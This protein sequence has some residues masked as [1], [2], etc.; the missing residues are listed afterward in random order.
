MQ[1][2]PSQIYSELYNHFGPQHWWPI[3]KTYHKHQKSDPRFEIIIGTILTQNTAWSNV[4]KALNND[5]HSRT[6]V[7]KITCLLNK[8]FSFIFLPPPFK[9]FKSKYRACFFK[10]F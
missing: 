5:A 9:F 8:F 7:M 3:D 4:E 1:I 6:V 2:N 10:S